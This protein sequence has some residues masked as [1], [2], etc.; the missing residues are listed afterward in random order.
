MGCYLQANHFVDAHRT[1]VQN[2]L[3]AEVPFPQRLGVPDEYAALAEHI[4]TN[5][6]INGEVIRIDGGLR[7]KA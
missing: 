7:M 6:Y 5:R 1:C 4:I 2:D 3:A